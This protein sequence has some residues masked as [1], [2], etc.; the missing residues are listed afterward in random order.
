MI[1]ERGT[2]LMECN[3]I[4]YDEKENEIY[5]GI[6]KNCKP[7]QGKNITIYDNNLNISYIGDISNFTYNGKGKLY[8]LNSDKIYFDGFFDTDTFV[9]GKLYDYE[10][11]QVYEGAFTNNKPKNAKDIKL[12]K[13][14]GTILYIGDFFDVYIM[15][16]E[17]NTKA[18]N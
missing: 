4:L 9:Y 15:E 10:G 12:C 11:N 1:Y 17:K 5:T 2:P 6:L 14:D 7:E 18:K 3:G 16:K 13:G 8:F